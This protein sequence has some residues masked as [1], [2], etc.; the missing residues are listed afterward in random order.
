MRILGIDPGER[1]TGFAVSDELGIT[2]QGLDTFDARRDG[3]FIA[4]VA[5]VVDRLS[6]T[7]FVVGN[8]LHLSGD[9]S[10]S[11]ERAAALAAKLEKRFGLPVTMWDER[12][13]S[14]EAKRVLRGSRADK[15]S[16]DRLAAVLILQSF[17]DYR[18]NT[19]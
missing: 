5:Q 1:R 3:S 9:A 12:L 19:S 10:P 13:S 4:Y 17:L 8:P 6:V 16:V 18:G 14:Q 11:S 2:A 15:R 7:E